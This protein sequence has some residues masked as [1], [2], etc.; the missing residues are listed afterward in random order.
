[1]I[2]THTD[3][4][5]G[6]PMSDRQIRD[7]VLTLLMAGHDTT[8][9]AL[10]W[11]QHLLGAN[12]A[13]AAQLESEVDDVLGD[14]LPSMA[15]L[16][17]LQWTRA[18]LNE[19]MRIYPP[20]WTVARR[21]LTPHTLLGHTVPADTTVMMSAWVVHRDSRWWPAP[22]RFA[23]QRWVERAPDGSVDNLTGTALTAERPRF[24]YFPFGGGP[25]QC[26]GNEFALLEGTI[27]LATL[28]RRWR[29][30]PVP[31]HR[32]T[33]QAKIIVRPRGGLPMTVRARDNRSE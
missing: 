32:V 10:A 16:P 29:L 26:I 20:V 17:R 22:E 24:S 2:I 18:V 13:A 30:E 19:A 9:N 7:E 28:A 3:A 14:R 1:L 33:P 4:D 11:A 25:R 21:A 27:V 23:P 8:A 31:G 12:P 15:D 5:T 6:E